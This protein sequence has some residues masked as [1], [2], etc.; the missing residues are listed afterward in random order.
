MTGRHGSPGGGNKLVQGSPSDRRGG[1][2]LGSEGGS[3]LSARSL[4]QSKF[5]GFGPSFFSREFRGNS[6]LLAWHTHRFQNEKARVQSLDL[7]I[8]SLIPEG[9]VIQNVEFPSEKSS[10]TCPKTSFSSNFQRENAC[11]QR[12]N[13]AKKT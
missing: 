2:D 10:K 13:G 9:K 1:P 3:G 8:S 5:P 12:G 4:A 6:L 7:T 11:F